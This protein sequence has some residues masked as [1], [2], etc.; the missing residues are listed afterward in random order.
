MYS[1]STLTNHRRSMSGF[2]QLGKCMFIYIAV[3]FNNTAG[4]IGTQRSRSLLYAYLHAE[5]PCR[6]D[7]VEIYLPLSI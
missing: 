4:L 7:T 1:L 2:L 5:E 3:R 6:F